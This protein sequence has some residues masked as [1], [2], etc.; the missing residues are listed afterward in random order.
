MTATQ[1][2]GLDM[3]DELITELADPF[4][5]KD[6]QKEGEFFDA[7][8][9][10]RALLSASKPAAPEGWKLVPGEPTPEMM[11]AGLYQSSRDSTS[12]DVHSIWKDMCAFAPAAP[13]QSAEPVALTAL[14]QLEDACD[15]IATLRTREQYL[16]MID[17]GQQDALIE[18]DN[19][20]M[21]ARNALRG[22]AVAQPVA[23]TDRALTDDARDAERYRH[24]RECNGGSLIIVQITGMGEDDQVVLTECDAD[25]AID[26]ALAKQAK[27][28]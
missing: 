11:N 14:R 19:A 3:T 4:W 25:T 13:A 15:K 6:A 23:Q 1:P 12:A 28:V 26:A 20:R 24:L 18:L 27:G 16:S 17:G 7:N 10:A 8:G 2:E 5:L 9:F 21:L 22:P